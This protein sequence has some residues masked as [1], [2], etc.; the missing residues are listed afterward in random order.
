MFWVHDPDAGRF[1][2]TLF[3]T[4]SYLAWE[5][6]IRLHA[7]GVFPVDHSMRPL[8]DG[9]EGVE[10]VLRIDQVQ[11]ESSE[12]NESSKFSGRVVQCV[13]RLRESTQ[14]RE[15]SESSE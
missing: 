5:F 15:S 6:W 11:R 3:R 14:S 4:P 12:S 9:A 1:G 8:I 10:R 2:G 13:E 7:K